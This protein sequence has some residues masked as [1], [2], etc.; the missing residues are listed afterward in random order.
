MQECQSEER[1]HQRRK[2]RDALTALVTHEEKRQR[3]RHGEKADGKDVGIHRSVDCAGIGHGGEETAEDSTGVERHAVVVEQLG[4]KERHGQREYHGTHHGDRCVDGKRRS[5][6]GGEYNKGAQL[7]EGGGIV[8]TGASEGVCLQ[9]ARSEVG[10]HVEGRHPLRVRK[11]ADNAQVR[12]VVPLVDEA[13]HVGA[14]VEIE[15]RAGDDPHRNV[16]A[17]SG[18]R[19]TLPKPE[20][21]L[22]GVPGKAPQRHRGSGGNGKWGKDGDD[23]RRDAHKVVD[24]ARDAHPR[25]R[26]SGR[27]HERR[28]CRKSHGEKGHP[29]G[30]VEDE[31]H[32]KHRYEHGCK[33]PELAIVF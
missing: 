7:M 20:G 30:D 32:E 8:A 25:N 13:A 24:N 15:K 11:S 27:E 22:R 6:V 19:E 26:D 23:A 3:K 33:A 5:D 10:A 31:K 14:L 4:D 1:E 9:V 12:V 16:E 29:T 17:G 2:G 18:D 28:K 21:R